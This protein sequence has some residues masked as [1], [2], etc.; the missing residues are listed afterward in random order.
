MTNIEKELY[1]SFLYFIKEANSNP[2]SQGYGLIADNSKNHHMASV[3]A[4]GFGLTAYVIGVENKYMTYQEGL[5]R[6][7]GT[8]KTFLYNVDQYRG[9]FIHFA[10]IDS[11]KAYKKSEYSTID[12]ALFLN[13]AITCDSYFDDSEV[14]YLFNQIYDR[15]EFNHFVKDF[16]NRKVFHM[17]YNPIEGGDYRHHSDNPWIHQWDM[18]A[19]QL[20]LYF[21][22][23]GS[24]TIDETLANQLYQGFE[25]KIGRYK[26]YEYLYSPPNALFIYQ[27]PHA[28]FDFSK[29]VDASGFDWFENSRQAS[30]C[31]RQYCIDNTSEFP[32]LNEQAWG[33]TACLTPLGY[34]NQHVL[35][36]DLPA[37]DPH[38][39]GVLPPSGALGSIPFTPKESLEVLNYLFDTYPNAFQEYGFRDGIQ[40]QQDQSIWISDHDIGINKGITLL[41][42]DNYLHQTTWTYYMKHPII[43]K[44]INVLHFRK[45]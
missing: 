7:I 6:V 42:L 38:G 13:G 33:L 14:H 35:P 31:N 3:A 44:A 30:L 17:A 27:Y 12:T 15:I 26:S 18:Y 32:T 22:A 23:A 24:N 34:R 11:G 40:I 19:E 20:M 5:K 2:S 43:Q 10:D 1:H 16:K 29:Y 21:Q 25:R 28:W 4:V 36:N 41:M 45:K 8:F 9:F 37:N 39:F